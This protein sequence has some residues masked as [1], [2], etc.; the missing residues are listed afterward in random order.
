MRHSDPSVPCGTSIKSWIL[1]VTGALTRWSKA[2]VSEMRIRNGE[3]EWDGESMDEEEEEE[4]RKLWGLMGVQLMN[5]SV[6]LYTRYVSETQVII[7]WADVWWAWCEPRPSHV[8]SCSWSDTETRAS[9]QLL[10]HYHFNCRALTSQGELVGKVEQKKLILP[11]DFFLFKRVRVYSWA[12]GLAQAEA[13]EKASPI[14]FFFFPIAPN[15][16]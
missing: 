11:S 15:S 7:L 10:S 9:L 1:Y 8:C 2:S 5:E 14:A 12:R 6:A 13:T 4:E 16:N 3:E